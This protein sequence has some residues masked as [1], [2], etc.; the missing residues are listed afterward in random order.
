M[1]A[2]KSPPAPSVADALLDPDIP[3]DH[4]VGAFVEMVRAKNTAA[5]KLAERILLAARA[6]NADEQLRKR[7]A[8][9]DELL[10]GLRQ[11]PRRLAIYFGAAPGPGPARAVAR[12]EDGTTVYPV[13]PDAQSM[14]T[15]REG[16]FVCL[17]AKASVILGRAP[18]GATVGEI[19]RL[20]RII[21]DSQVEVTLAHGDQRRVLSA[22][23]RLRD[24]LADGSVAPGAALIVCV[25]R[26]IA[27]AAAP[28][29]D[30]LAHL[31][32]LCREPIPDTTPDRDIG[33]PPAFIED[34]G[35][36]VRGMLLDPEGR[37]AY[38][39]RPTKFVLLEG[40]SGSGKSLSVCATIRLVH[41]VVE[42]V[43]GL[44]MAN[45]P[46]AVVRVRASSFLSKYLGESDKNIDRLFDELAQ[47]AR[48]RIE[49][50]GRSW[51]MP[52]IL[53]IEEFDAIARRRGSDHEAVYDRV[54]TTFLQRLDATTNPS[55]SQGI[56]VGLFTTNRME[57]SD[58]AFLRRI[59]GETITFGRLTRRS[60]SAVLSKH[61]RGLPLAGPGSNRRNGTTPEAH[62]R[63]LVR[64]VTDRLFAPD[65][66]EER[67]VE[68]TLGGSAR[69][70]TKSRCDFLT[71]SIIDRAVQRAAQ[72]ACR[73]HE[74][75]WAE[76][77]VITADTIADA[78][79]D[80]VDALVTQLSPAN[81]S[82]Y[83]DVP[84]GSRVAEVRRIERPALRPFRLRA[85]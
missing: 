1:P 38:R 54:L 6:G 33:D 77:A 24:S 41:E 10:D 75:G 23:A 53:V 66:E 30:H 14:R 37:R 36:F 62:E 4:A 50:R 84:S 85:S 44:P 26:D 58:P 61:V 42:E 46:P 82:E 68:I 31:K 72:D 81:A 51:P 55:L 34:T 71:G 48:R 40:V 47:L 22:S 25:R 11:G 63:D 35:S 80:Q 60:F 17:D 67:V 2:T 45:H 18:D 13:V 59:G 9:A 64:E 19:A 52:V 39:L 15:V 32:F 73:A 28:P 27:L 3:L 70:L 21:D 49:T 65:A 12:L 69:T 57:L 56:I 78:I 79:A 8:E 16:D 76:G 43:T 74:E 20:E 7:L 5:P 83:I 29:T